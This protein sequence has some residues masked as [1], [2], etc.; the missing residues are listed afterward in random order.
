MYAWNCL[1]YGPI[2]CPKEIGSVFLLRNERKIHKEKY[3]WINKPV[4][5]WSKMSGIFQLSP[6]NSPWQQS[7]LRCRDANGKK[8]VSDIC[9]NKIS[10][11]AFSQSGRI[12]G[13]CNARFRVGGSPGRAG[14]GEATPSP[15]ACLH[16]FRVLTVA[17]FFNFLT[18][19]ADAF[20]F[21][22]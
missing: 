11:A 20:N 5:D 8:G 4:Y 15:D 12:I 1:H 7:F 21:E 16:I 22:S 13:Q 14:G 3:E 2:K 9:G 6:S 10:A 19:A 18:S 17:V